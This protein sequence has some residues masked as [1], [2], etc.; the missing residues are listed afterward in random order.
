MTTEDDRSDGTGTYVADALRM[1]AGIVLFPFLWIGVAVNFLGLAER[2]SFLPGISRE[3]GVVSGVVAFLLTA[4]VLGV[5]VGGASAATGGSMPVLGGEDDEPATDTTSTAIPTPTSTPTPTPTPMPTPTPTAT[6]MPTPQLSDL[7][8]FETNFR[9]RLQY[10]V[11]N[12][13]LTPIPVLATEYRETDDGTMELWVVYRECDNVE[14]V[15]TQRYS[16]AVEFA[17]T[18]G[19]FEGE[20]PD[21]LRAYGVLSLE[22]YSS[23]ITH[24]PTSSAEAAFNESMDR[25][26]YAENWNQ[27]LREPTESESEIAYQMVVNDS[28]RTKAEQVFHEQYPIE[29]SDRGCHGTPEDGDESGTDQR[30]SGP[31]VTVAAEPVAP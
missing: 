6:P 22:S 28:G 2:F 30:I 24:I 19:L 16:T 20:Q 23:A 27:R 1:I 18:A 31:G 14:D 21:R 7:G 4:A 11:E 5:V 29:E 17:N 10:T 15:R 8:R 12:D 26:K 13:T 9:D 3:G 25:S